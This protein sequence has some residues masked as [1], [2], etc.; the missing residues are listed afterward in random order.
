MKLMKKIIKLNSGYEIREPKPTHHLLI[1]FADDIPV[2]SENKREQQ[3]IFEFM[4][5][6]LKQFE[7]ISVDDRRDKTLFLRDLFREITESLTTSLDKKHNNDIFNNF[8]NTEEKKK[9]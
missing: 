6:Y 4:E 3:H 2:D 9:I 7:N 8:E 1:P 5:D